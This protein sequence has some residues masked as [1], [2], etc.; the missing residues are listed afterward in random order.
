[1]RLER[2]PIIEEKGFDHV[3][4]L[5]A[6]SA[7]KRRMD[8][9]CI[10]RLFHNHIDFIIQPGYIVTCNPCRVLTGSLWKIPLGFL[11]IFSIGKAAGMLKRP[12]NGSI[13]IIIFNSQME[14]HRY[15]PQSW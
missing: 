9:I 14:N 8:E 11:T 13:V 7:L 15:S 3:G 2:F 4:I 6:L 12:S 1:M 5:A 10:E